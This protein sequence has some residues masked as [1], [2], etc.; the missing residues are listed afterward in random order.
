MTD[1]SHQQI[2]ES[3]AITFKTPTGVAVLN[4]LRQ[5][6]YDTDTF[7]KDPYV[8]ARNAGRRD[9]IRLITQLRD[10]PERDHAQAQHNNSGEQ[11]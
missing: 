2:A 5:L 3:Y 1:N 9:V 11:E 10:K 4:H 8:H 6:F 7:D